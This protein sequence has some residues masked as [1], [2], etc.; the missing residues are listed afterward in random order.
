MTRVNE[1]LTAQPVA[2]QLLWQ[3]G[4]SKALRLPSAVRDKHPDWK[5]Q[6]PTALYAADEETVQV[7]FVWK[8][9]DG[10]IIP[11]SEE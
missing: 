8:L 4:G 7:T 9:K 10:K 3:L 1:K 5:K 2:E 6:N 11:D